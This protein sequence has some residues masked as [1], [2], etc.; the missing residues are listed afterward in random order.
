MGFVGDARRRV[1]G[2]RP[3]RRLAREPCPPLSRRQR[4]GSLAGIQDR[5]P[6]A[7]RREERPP[8]SRCAP[9]AGIAAG[10]PR[11]AAP[12]EW[13]SR[14]A[15]PPAWHSG[16]IGWYRPAPA[17]RG[18]EYAGLRATRPAS[19]AGGSLLGRGEP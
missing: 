5:T 13:D 18:A 16:R 7:S 17:R 8:R 1:R 9:L 19:A 11:E 12:A 15:P 10:A 4:A 6:A 14:R 3:G 2:R